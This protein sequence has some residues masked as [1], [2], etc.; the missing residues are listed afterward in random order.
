[1][2]FSYYHD[3]YVA[4]ELAPGSLN[5]AYHPY[6]KMRQELECIDPTCMEPS[7]ACEA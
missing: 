5:M 6:Y 7:A 1:M 4:E 2:T 3:A